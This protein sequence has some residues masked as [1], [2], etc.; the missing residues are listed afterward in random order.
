MAE[1]VERAKIDVSLPFALS[2]IA[3][4]LIVAGSLGALTMLGWYP[5]M[6]G[7][8]SGMGGM[9]GGGWQMFMSGYV[10]SFVATMAAI[11]VAAGATVL[12][13]AYKMQKEPE[14]AQIWGFLVLVGSIVAL[15]CIGGFGLGSIVGIIGG[16]VAISRRPA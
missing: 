1:R 11:S 15:F 12:A 10:P 14:K 8:G 3:G 4:I 9:M 5:S 6:F 2:L 13:G 16:A 7:M